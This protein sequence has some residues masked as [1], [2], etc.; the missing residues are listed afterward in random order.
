LSDAIPS[1]LQLI[2]NSCSLTGSAHL[3]PALQCDNNLVNWQGVLSDTSAITVTFAVTVS[4]T[5]PQIITNTAVISV[6]GSPILTRTALLT[7]TP[8]D[9]TP[10]LTLSRKTAS[11]EFARHGQRITYTV[12]IRNSAGPLTHTVFLTDTIPT[13]MLYI[14]GTLTAT[15]GLVTDTEVPTLRWS[16]VLTPSPVVTITYAAAVTYTTPGSTALLPA[17]ITNTAIIAAPGYQSIT[18]TAS[19]HVN[20]LSVYLPLILKGN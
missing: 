19:V 14:P 3:P 15:A 17:V 18:R 7:V 11:P 13:G 1:G 10:N 9:N 4:A 20:W 6:P 16:G 2:N 5:V 12:S 8:P